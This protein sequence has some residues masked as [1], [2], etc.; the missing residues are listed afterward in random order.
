MSDGPGT[1]DVLTPSYGYG[2]FLADALDSVALQRGIAC[3][4]IVQDGGSTDET[5]ALLASRA[6]DRLL[7]RSEPDDGQSDA[8]NR[9]LALSDA[10]W[11]A[12]LN[13]DEFYLPGALQHLVDAATRSGADVI[14]GD[15]VFVDEGGSFVR[16]LPQHRFSRFVLRHYGAHISTCA[17]VARRSV[18]DGV[19]WRTGFRKVMD[20]DLYVRLLRA[21][22]R[23][24]YTPFP[25]GA[26]RL[27]GEQVTAGSQREY[28]DEYERMR[29]DLGVRPTRLHELGARVAHAA[30]KG[31]GSAYRRQRAAAALHGSDMRWFRSDGEA[32]RLL[33]STVYDRAGVG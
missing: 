10:P 4:H 1:V 3:R 17:M 25:V 6:G 14:Y 23:F 15:A 11:I 21:G 30:L 28:D 20:W 24:E 5:T 19:R 9:A 29:S 32:A 8:L 27:H 2:R 22:A 33:L 26:F 18:V 12:W 16:L 7:W 31:A 13:A